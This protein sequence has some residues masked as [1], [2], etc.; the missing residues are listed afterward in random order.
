MDAPSS[1]RRVTVGADESTVEE[2]QEKEAEHPLI[3]CWIRLVILSCTSVMER[4]SGIAIVQ[5]PTGAVEVISV[6]D[7]VIAVVSSM[8]ESSEETAATMLPDMSCDDDD[9]DGTIPLLDAPSGF[10][11][12]DDARRSVALLDDCLLATSGGGKNS[13]ED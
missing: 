1:P 7:V 5:V 12:A 9:D 2:P 4:L 13:P 6:G 3:H 11:T 10:V 8:G